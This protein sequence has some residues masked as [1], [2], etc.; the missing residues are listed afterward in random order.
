M[1]LEG[2]WGNCPCAL[3]YSPPGK[4]LMLSVTCLRLSDVSII[5][6]ATYLQFPIQAF[7]S[8]MSVSLVAQRSSWF[9]QYRTSNIVKN[10][11]TQVF[12]MELTAQGNDF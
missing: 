11:S 8:S 7:F 12:R 6:R 9:T 5:C 3:A 4:M 2:A 1:A 10:F